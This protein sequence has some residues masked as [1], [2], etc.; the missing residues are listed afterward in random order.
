MP[1]SGTF[2]YVLIPADE[3]KPIEILTANKAGGLSDDALVQ[4]AKQYFHELTGA[5]ERSERLSKAGPAERKA[6]ASQIR[7]QLA[8]MSQ[9]EQMD[10]DTVLDRIYQ[11]QAQPSCD[12][13]ALTIPCSGNNYR[14]VSMYAADNAQPHGLSNNKRATALMT[15]CGHAAVSGG[16][17]GDVFVGRARDDE[18]AD[19]WERV[20]FTIEDTDPSAAWCKEARSPGGGGGS[21]KGAASSLSGLVAQQQQ[22]QNL[23]VI[24]SGG[25]QA[26]MLY[27]YNG[28]PPV[29]ESWGSW[30]QT[31]DEVELKFAVAPGT[32]AKYCKVSFQRTALKVA[33]AGQTL[34][35]GTA[36]DPIATEE[37]TFTLQDEGPTGRE[38]CVTIGKTEPRTWSYVV[39]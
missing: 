33:V 2:Q 6:L 27:G 14:A 30:T 23:Q 36:F 12:I 16:V 39:Q 7:Q 21:G 15:A 35:Q 18:N 28:A 26:T 31:D 1:L 32:K 34:L 10:D 20:D 3:S 25:Q 37:S 24:D 8:D 4:S 22:G 38:L 29:Q 5:K 17:F 11:S 13:M 9:L 19:I